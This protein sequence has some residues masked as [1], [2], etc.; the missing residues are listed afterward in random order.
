[1]QRWRRK[2][3]S[4]RL[5]RASGDEE[6]HCFAVGISPYS[7]NKFL[8]GPAKSYGPRRVGHV[9]ARPSLHAIMSDEPLAASKLKPIR[10]GYLE[11]EL[12]KNP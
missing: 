4:P 12:G 3:L 2:R 9:F 6:T 7:R 10:E 5:S 1:M 8:L 11:L